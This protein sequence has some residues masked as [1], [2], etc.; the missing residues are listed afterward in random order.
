[1]GKE[2]FAENFGEFSAPAVLGCRQGWG[3]GGFS[4]IFS[5]TAV[6]SYKLYDI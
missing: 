5:L 2:K 6:I 1:M 3:I 4:L